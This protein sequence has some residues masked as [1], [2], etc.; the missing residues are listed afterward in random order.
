MQTNGVKKTR[1]ALGRLALLGLLALASTSTSAWA[2][3]C[4]DQVESL[5]DAYNLTIDPPDV[6]TRGSSDPIDSQDLAQSGGVIEPPATSDGSVI[7]PPDDL[8]YG[9]ETVP[10]PEP[11]PLAPIEPDALSASDRMI[12]E[13]VLMSARVDAE[14]GEELDCFNKLQKAKG[15]LQP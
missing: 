5:A 3:S 10:T 4:L 2:S 8:Q 1:N 14:R 9:M 6:A 12:A 7:E 11:G 15:L 13:S